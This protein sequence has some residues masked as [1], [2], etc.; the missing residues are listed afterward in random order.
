MS[1]RLSSQL[2]GQANLQVIKQKCKVIDP[3]SEIIFSKA[4]PPR[5]D[6]LGKLLWKVFRSNFLIILGM[7]L[8]DL[9][10]I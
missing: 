1:H 5:T 10:A 8:G 2:H 7:D 3:T 4:E 6:I 9:G